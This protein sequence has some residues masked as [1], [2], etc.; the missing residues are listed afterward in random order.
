MRADPDMHPPTEEGTFHEEGI[1]HEDF[2]RRDPFLPK[3][4]GPET[5]SMDK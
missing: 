2:L 3:M 4:K 5:P 1:F